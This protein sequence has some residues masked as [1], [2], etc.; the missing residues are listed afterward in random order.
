MH[1]DKPNSAPWTRVLLTTASQ[2]E[3]KGPTHELFEWVS[4]PAATIST[5]GLWWCNEEFPWTA[6]DN[7]WHEARE[8]YSSGSAT[9]EATP[10]NLDDP[11]QRRAGPPNS[12]CRLCS[13]YDVDV[14]ATLE[15]ARLQAYLVALDEAGSA[16]DR[17]RRLVP[18]H[19]LDHGVSRV[20]AMMLE[21]AE[22]L[23][24]LVR[25][26]DTNATRA[27]ATA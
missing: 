8:I 20:N 17:A 13:P 4:A 7:D 26:A 3:P 21:A 14:E 6:I 1:G 24:D 16:M 25:R 23:D 5:E 22:R 15:I 19:G 12:S 2:P 11:G 27:N 9:E 10:C 18:D